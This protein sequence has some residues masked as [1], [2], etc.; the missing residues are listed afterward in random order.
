MSIDLIKRSELIRGLTN[1]EQDSNMTAI[2]TFINGLLTGT[3]GYEA[4][5]ALK[6]GG[7]VASGFWNDSNCTSGGST[8]T[9]YVKFKSGLIFQ[10]GRISF[11]TAATQ[12]WTL[13]IAFPAYALYAHCNVIW[14][15]NSPVAFLDSLGLS[16]VDFRLNLGAVYITGY[17]FAIGL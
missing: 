2:E 8:F 4:G 13:P 14:P 7:V 16:S 17:C 12:T 10:W 9:G 5:N 15:G 6:L 1:S 3:A 11:Q